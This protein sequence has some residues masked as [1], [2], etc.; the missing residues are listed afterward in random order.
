[1]AQFFLK[2][3]PYQQNSKTKIGKFHHV[4]KSILFVSKWCVFRF[5]KLVNE[6]EGRRDYFL[7]LF[8]EI[9]R[10]YSYH[11]YPF[12]PSFITWIGVIYVHFLRYTIFYLVLEYSRYYSSGIGVIVMAWQQSGGYPYPDQQ[13]VV[14]NLFLSAYLYVSSA[15]LT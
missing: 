10:I 12:S 1:M 4:Y 3:L 14:F 7:A 13:G 9:I 2:W 5:N 8:E 11:S 6:W 15:L